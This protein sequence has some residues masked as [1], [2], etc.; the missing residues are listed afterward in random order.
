M[1][2]FKSCRIKKIIRSIF[3]YFLCFYSTIFQYLAIVLFKLDINK[4]HG[5]YKVAVLLSTFSSFCVFI[6]LFLLY[7][8]DL[9]SEFRKFKKD[10]IINL[11]T[12]L[13]CW[14][15]GLII[16]V[17]MN[18]LLVYVFKSNG[19]TNENEVQK[20]I[21]AFPL[22]MALDVCLLAPFNE[23]VVFRKAIYDVF[24]NKYIFIIL[25]FLI[26]GGAHVLGSAKTLVD[27]L[28][29][30]PYGALGGMFAIAYSKT[31]TVFTSMT[32]H[33]FHNTILFLIS[34]FI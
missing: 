19:A 18:L 13:A 34:V 4:L 15:L 28:Y 30:I 27:Y 10:L 11:D 26:F 22:V 25:S 20:L 23:E 2:I 7:R 24:K 17:C 32:F 16:M 33:I 14:F 12:G 8:K 29:I 9:V 1:S 6:I 21:S 31:D 3:T 5:N